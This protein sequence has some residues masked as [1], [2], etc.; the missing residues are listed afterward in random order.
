M[1]G[2]MV[3]PM[4]QYKD[5]I[6]DIFSATQSDENFFYDLFRNQFQTLYWTFFD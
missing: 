4:E 3:R 6:F 5:G 2:P 1:V